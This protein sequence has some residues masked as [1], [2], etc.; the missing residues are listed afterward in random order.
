ME[1]VYESTASGAEILG[2]PENALGFS[3]PEYG[4]L[5]EIFGQPRSSAALVGGWGVGFVD[6]CVDVVVTET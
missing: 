2:L 1:G 3:L 4:N 6:C 5:H